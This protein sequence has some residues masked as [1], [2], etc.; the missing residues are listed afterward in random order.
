MVM[1]N[2]GSLWQLRQ[3]G[4]CVLA[5]AT[6]VE[7]GGGGVCTWWWVVVVAIGVD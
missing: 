2:G 6:M 5:E 1:G 4:V 3:Q 7:M